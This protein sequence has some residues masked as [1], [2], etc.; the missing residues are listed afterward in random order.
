MSDDERGLFDNNPNKLAIQVKAATQ[1]QSGAISYSD[2]P[3]TMKSHVFPHLQKASERL[4]DCVLSVYHFILNRSIKEQ[5][6]RLQ[7][8]WA[9]SPSI[10][11]LKSC[12]ARGAQ[13]RKVSFA[14]VLSLSSSSLSSASEKWE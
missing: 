8:V 10:V 5:A 9:H 6:P 2:L 4:Y 13:R 11:T 3:L 14:L 12:S 1:L 7:R